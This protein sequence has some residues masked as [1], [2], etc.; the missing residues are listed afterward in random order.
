MQA[1]MIEKKQFQETENGN[2]KL[3]SCYLH[4]ILIK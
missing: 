4:E 1:F 3:K 2:K